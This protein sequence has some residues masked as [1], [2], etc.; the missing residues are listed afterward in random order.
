MGLRKVAHLRETSVQKK[1]YGGKCSKQNNITICSVMIELAQETQ[2]MQRERQSK[3][4][5]DREREREGGGGIQGQELGCSS[6]PYNYQ[7]F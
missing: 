1:K 2:I 4:G 6:S 7:S 5:R 3:S